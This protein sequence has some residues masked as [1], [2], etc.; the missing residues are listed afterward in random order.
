[1]TPESI[2]THVGAMIKAKRKGMKL[3]QSELAG[4]LMISRASLAN[5]ECG[6]QRV[7]VHQLYA[8][9]AA[10]QLAP[11][12]LL[13]P[14]DANRHIDLGALPLP[15]GLKAEQKQQIARLFEGAPAE[16]NQRKG[17]RNVNDSKR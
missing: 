14:L 10:L 17:G 6:R 2:Y 9:A 5:I 3:T 16:S 7:L 4:Q 8:F 12:D 1:M 13:P 11:S 15:G